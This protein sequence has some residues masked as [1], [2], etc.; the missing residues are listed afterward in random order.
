MATGQVVGEMARQIY[1]C[2][3]G[4]HIAA[5]RGLRA[6]IAETAALISGGGDAPIFEATFDYAGL[7]VQVDVLD[8]SSNPPRIVE[9]KSSTRVKTH[10]VLDCAIQ[11]A[12]LDQLGQPADK[13]S[14]AHINSEFV[15]LGDDNYSELFKETDVTADVRNLLPEVPTWVAAARATLQEIDEPQ[16]PIG[17]HCRSPYRCPFFD[18]CAP[19]QG[20]YS[21]AGLGGRKEKLDALMLDGFTDIRDVPEDRL[22]NEQQRRIRQQTIAEAPYIGQELAAFVNA[23]S[24]PRYYLD[25]ETVGFAIPIWADTKP[26]QAAPFQWSCHTDTG[27]GEL[28]HAEFL[29]LSGNPPMRACAETLIAALDVRGPILVYTPYEK[30]VIH[31]LA[32]RFPDLAPALLPLAERIVDLHPQIKKHYYHPAMLGSWS[33]KSVLPTIAPEIDYSSL[34]E[35]KDG[36]GAQ[37]AYLE[38]IKPDTSRTRHEQLRSALLEYCRTDT[39]AMVKLLTQF[40]DS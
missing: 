35:V 34:G 20:K 18:H 37:T 5:H 12:V 11:A 33:I 21:V 15:Y 28:T 3:G 13:I 36:M 8:R 7:T 22:D 9:V 27:S 19:Q 1:G 40:G 32:E 23:L 25:F 29:D 6:A 38:A 24:T 10:H 2:R 31:E 14:I 30:R 17:E 16:N 26:Y 39:L 4:H